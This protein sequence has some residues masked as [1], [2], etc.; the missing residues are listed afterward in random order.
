MGLSV[1]MRL[2]RFPGD[3]PSGVPRIP[4]ERVL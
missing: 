2:G 4:C 3:S 1:G